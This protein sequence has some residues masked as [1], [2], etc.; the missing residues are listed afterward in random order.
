MRSTAQNTPSSNA[1]AIPLSANMRATQ[2]AN[3]RAVQQNAQVTASAPSRPAQSQPDIVMVYRIFMSAIVGSILYHLAR[4]KSVIPLNSRTFVA[5]R[6]ME[7]ESASDS[8]E[9][10][11]RSIWLINVDVHLATTGTL[12]VATTATRQP[13]VLSLQKL[14]SIQDVTRE[15]N[16]VL[17]VSPNGAIVRLMHE[18]AS[19]DSN[20]IYE[21]REQRRKRLKRKS[22]QGDAQAWKSAV[23]VWLERRGVHLANL[24]DEAAWVRIRLPNQLRPRPVNSSN[25]NRVSI[26]EFLWP[27]RLCLCY[28]SKARLHSDR[29]S[30]SQ[31]MPEEM[32]GFDMV[33]CIDWF[34]AEDQRGFRDP[35]QFPQ[36]WV[37]DKPE[38]DKAIGALQQPQK[39]EEEP[40]TTQI[41]SAAAYP[42]S[43]LYSRGMYPDMQTASGVYPTP[44][45]GVFIPGPGGTALIDGPNV[46][47]DNS[48]AHVEH[49][50]EGSQR[51][52]ESKNDIKEES[53]DSHDHENHQAAYAPQGSDA[54]D[55]DA[56]FNDG[57]DDLFEDMDEDM[58][59]GTGNDITEADFSFFDDPG[60]AGLNS[61]DMDVATEEGHGFELEGFD[62]SLALSTLR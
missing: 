49:D 15:Q 60:A 32:S 43:P 4:S 56:A 47:S 51:Q 54:M 36:D 40:A 5:F 33:R 46:A 25:A 61:S 24:N 13:H 55:F 6:L 20:G 29:H 17:R 37:V 45:D 62:G 22:S 31:V 53:F 44:P 39:A 9:A 16:Y 27:T 52:E 19:Q 11:E 7:T 34:Q 10:G 1:S 21:G 2:A 50:A 42:S 8:P 35:F 41:D 59:A 12:L 18:E 38:R 57:N 3:A 48:D 28:L 14:R 23:Q 26:R 58:F 30:S